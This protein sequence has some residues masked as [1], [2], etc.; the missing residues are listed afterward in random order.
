[1]PKV[2]DHEQRRQELAQAL[3]RVVDRAGFEGATVRAVATE[4]NWSMGALRY[5]FDSQQRLLHFAVEILIERIGDRLRAHLGAGIAGPELARRLM[6][7]FLPLDSDRGVEVTVW[8]AAL[9][10]ARTDPHLAALRS[11]SWE[12]TRQVCRL[13]IVE[14]RGAGRPDNSAEPLRPRRLEDTAAA[15]H[16]YIDGLTLHASRYPDQNPPGA[17]REALHTYLAALAG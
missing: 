12:G 5:Y 2:V 6:E 1:M 10:R 7:E 15:L 8:L 14:L 9:E 17:V 11:Q 13:A 4:A 16:T 3:W